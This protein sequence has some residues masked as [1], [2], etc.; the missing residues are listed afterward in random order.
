M[1]TNR[2]GMLNG[3]R[4]HGKGYEAVFQVGLKTF[5]K[6]FKN[7]KQAAEWILKTKR[8]A[9]RKYYLAKLASL[10]SKQ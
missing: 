9:L 10:S 4:K 2:P 8:Q 1:K 7:K 3:I 6:K 5:W